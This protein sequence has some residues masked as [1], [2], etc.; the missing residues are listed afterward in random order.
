MLQQATLRDD[1]SL[2][3]SAKWLAAVSLP[4]ADPVAI[5]TTRRLINSHGSSRFHVKANIFDRHNRSCLAEEA[6]LPFVTV[7]HEPRYMLR[8]WKHHL[9]PSLTKQFDLIFILDCDVWWTPDIFSPSAV[10]RWMDST[11]ARIVQPSVLAACK[12]VRGSR[13]CRSAGAARKHTEYAADCAAQVAPVVERL[14]ISR[15]TAYGV[16]WDI[17]NKIPD[18]RLD[19]DLGVMKLWCVQA[20]M[21]FPEHPACVILRSLA[22]VHDNTKTINK[23]GFDYKYL[24]QKAVQTDNTVIYIQQ[25]WGSLLSNYSLDNT[26][27]P[28][29]TCWPLDDDSPQRVVERQRVAEPQN[30]VE[31]RRK[32]KPSQGAKS[33]EISK[34]E[35]DPKRQQARGQAH[36]HGQAHGQAHGYGHG[37]GRALAHAL[38]DA[39]VPVHVH[40]PGRSS[41]NQG[42]RWEPP[43]TARNWTKVIMT[44]AVDTHGARCLDGGPGGFYI[45]PPAAAT[46]D[47]NARWLV[48]HQGGGWC[49]SPENCLSRSKT[50]LGSSAYWP[51]TYEDKY[52]GSALWTTPPFD[53][54]TV[55]YAMYCDGGSWAGN[56][57]GT[58]GNATL[59]YRGRNLLDALLDTLLARGLRG[60]S[61]L[62]YAGCSAGG[63]TAYLHAD[64]VRSKVPSSVA[65]L[66]LADAMFALDHAAFDGQRRFPAVMQ[67]VY[68]AM[69]CSASINARC[70]SHYGEGGGWRC[71]LGAL[72]APFVQ[73]PLFV[74]NSKYDTWQEVAILGLDCA[75]PTCAS[76]RQERFWVGYGQA[77]VAAVDAL[78][79]RHAAFLMNCP[80]HCQT[81]TGGD[82]GARR[83]GNT[84]NAAAVAWWWHASIGRA[85]PLVEDLR[86]E[87]VAPRWVERCDEQP[88]SG[89][90]C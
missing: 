63:L 42:H 64:Y 58:V 10:E 83:V 73:L 60:A 89:D 3:S 61:Q 31:H 65:M 87:W 80:A 48:F 36:G 21:A 57:T 79:A 4:S 26:S 62:L 82:W 78:P 53:G 39:P 68:A 15:S 27:W 41:S 16:L 29:R 9:T 54:F 24:N 18:H 45:S 5:H 30:G 46:S 74:L 77:M 25:H 22:V 75:P 56:A 37:H 32:P 13:T 84:S 38:H 11:R 55:V 66:G 59:H 49:G 44:E 88:C 12:E 50:A 52:E 20:Q 6:T 23:A 1:P 90:A 8:F 33:H 28:L 72:A 2:L 17:L 19:T 47:P 71:M 69:G 76:A 40:A 85:T 81:G 14:H 43:A 86:G 51:D 70:L 35:G 7:T 67:W 34:A